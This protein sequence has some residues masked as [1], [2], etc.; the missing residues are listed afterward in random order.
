MSKVVCIQENGKT[1]E[2]KNI[3]CTRLNY[4]NIPS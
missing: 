2:K 1:L 4:V 3:I